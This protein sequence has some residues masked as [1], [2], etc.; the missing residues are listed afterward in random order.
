LTLPVLR[1]GPVEEMMMVNRKITFVTL[2]F[3]A[4]VSTGCTGGRSCLFGRGARCGLCSR[5]GAIGGAV[6]PFRRNNPAPPACNVP[7]ASVAPPAY[8][9]QAHAPACNQ[10]VYGGP[11]VAGDCGCG[12]AYGG[13]TMGMPAEPSCE[14]CQGGSTVYHGV[15]PYLG[16]SSYG[17][18]V[19]GNEMILDGG[20]GTSGIMSD[21]FQPR[22]YGARK[23]DAQGDVIVREDPLPPGA[24]V[25]P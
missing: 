3:L 18:P 23:V 6:N 11:M 25:M 7:Y 19:M 9:P 14:S 4:M 8:A 16:T 5:V 21:D 1:D 24:R 15:D 22:Q 13:Y 20:Y 10:P 12:P 2:A 17:A